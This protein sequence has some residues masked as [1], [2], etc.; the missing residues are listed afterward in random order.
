M[1][2]L[3]SDIFRRVPVVTP[4]HGVFGVATAHAVNLIPCASETSQ[5]PSCVGSFTCCAALCQLT[6]H[7]PTVPPLFLTPLFLALRLPQTLA[8]CLRRILATIRH[9]NHKYIVCNQ[10]TLQ[11]LPSPFTKSVPFR[12]DPTPS[13]MHDPTVPHE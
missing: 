5:P 8:D 1:T 2:P 9:K 3:F 12:P 7:D 6:M 4:L 13:P 11:P 10:R